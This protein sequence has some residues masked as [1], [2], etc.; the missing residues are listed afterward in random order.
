[1]RWRNEQLYH[2]RQDKLLS[3]EDQ[4]NYF[5]NVISNLFDHKNPNQILFS[6]LKKN[7]CCGYGGLVHINW[8]DKNAEISFIM[9][10][11]LEKNNFKLHWINFLQLIQKVAFEDLGLYKIYI[12]AFNLRPHLFETIESFGFEKEATLKGHCFYQK[13]FIDVIIHSKWNKKWS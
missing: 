13:K 7:K 1:M 12:Y 5:N 9:N 11:S 2:L 3:K 4:D 6:Y 10:T 8:I